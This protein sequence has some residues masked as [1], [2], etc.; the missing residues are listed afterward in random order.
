MDCKK[1][2]IEA[3]GDADVASEV[4]GHRIESWVALMSEWSKVKQV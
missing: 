3:K 2:L 4:R 1:A